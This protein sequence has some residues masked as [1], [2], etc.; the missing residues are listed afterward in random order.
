MDTDSFVIYINPDDFY[1][2]LA[3]DVEKWFD[4]SKYSQDDNRPLLI[5]WNKKKYWFF[6][7]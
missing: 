7:R 6:Q 3:D 4:T 2:N 1:K 5:G